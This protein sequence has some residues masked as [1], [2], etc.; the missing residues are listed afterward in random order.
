MA[1]FNLK[2]RTLYGVAQTQENQPAIISAA[3]TTGTASVS[4][5][6]TT[7]T[8]S[9]T[10]FLLQLA[11]GIYVY[12]ASGAEVGQ[13]LS[14]ASD[15]SATI[16]PAMN[17]LSSESF[18]TGMGSKNA[19]PTTQFSFDR[20]IVSEAFQYLGDELDRDE[21]TTVTDN[22]AKFDFQAFMPRLGT[23]AGGTPTE[24]EVNLAK[25]MQSAGFAL[26]LSTGKA[27]FTNS[28]VT[29]T[30][31]TIE[32][33][34]ATPEL[35]T[36][37]VYTVVNARANIDLDCK[38]SSRANLKFN[39]M[40]NILDIKQKASITPDYGFQKDKVALPLATKRITR[41]NLEVY[42]DETEPTVGATNFCFSE[43]TAGNVDGFVYD[44]Y[45]TSC[46]ETWSKE[47]TPTDM[48][49][50]IVEDAADAT[51]APQDNLDTNHRLQIDYGDTAG[52][53]VSIIYNKIRLN[54]I[55]GSEVAKFVGETLNFRNVGYTTIE[56]T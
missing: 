37:K 15:T 56:L 20:E 48:A 29:N 13:V 42:V 53:R 39:Y 32:M 3:D 19:L 25:W 24:E 6:G 1:K 23:I 33:R 40:G 50:T 8:G 7:L 9:G 54:T 26:V 4:N 5:G 45:Q 21:V 2:A 44:R 17:P 11:I 52:D 49:L 34:M 51:Y 12:D 30:Y 46:E 27:S 55:S 41:S 47:A 36:D 35:S 10:Q 43:L 18:A 22:Y 16:S 14:V 38:I 31:M 28:Q